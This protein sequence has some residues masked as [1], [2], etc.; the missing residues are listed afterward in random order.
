MMTTDGH[1]AQFRKAVRVR[2]FVDPLGAMGFRKPSERLRRER[3]LRRFVFAATLTS[4]AG[5]FGAIASMGSA[6][7]S[8]VAQ[9]GVP[10]F[11]PAASGS[12]SGRVSSTQVGEENP[13][14]HT[15]SKAS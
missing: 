2:S 12:V 9:T 14:A 11:R 6:G 10:V 7:T 4:F 8:G 5:V 1:D 15:R 13:P 3:R